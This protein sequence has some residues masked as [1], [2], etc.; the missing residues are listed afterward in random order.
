MQI[1]IVVVASIA[2]LVCGAARADRVAGLAGIPSVPSRSAS[3]QPVATSPALL[4]GV[5][6]AVQ[7]DGA[8]VD[9]DG[10]RY[11]LERGRSLLLR[12]GLPVSTNV[13]AK[14][15]RLRFSLASATPGEMVLGVVHVP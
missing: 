7:A 6:S 13:L 11:A 4:S 15:Q 12:N 5:V 9:I 14:G 1:P 3:A 10:K 2:W 8:Y